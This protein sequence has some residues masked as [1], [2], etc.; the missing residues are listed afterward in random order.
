MLNALRCLYILFTAHKKQPFFLRQTR[1]LGMRSDTPLHTDA[2]LLCLGIEKLSARY[3]ISFASFEVHTKSE[4]QSGSRMRSVHISR[5]SPFQ[6]ESA[7]RLRDT[8]NRWCI[9]RARSNREFLLLGLYLIKRELY[10]DAARSH[11]R[12]HESVD[13]VRI[14]RVCIYYSVCECN[15]TYIYIYKYASI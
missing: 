3:N 13:I 7:A 2:F 9:P 1:R 4:N 11:A 5:E 12:I 6:I 10:T 15:M 8:I 14:A